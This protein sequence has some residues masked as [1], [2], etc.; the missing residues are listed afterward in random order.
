MGTSA[1]SPIR[2]RAAP[3]AETDYD[4]D[5]DGL[6]EVRQPRPAQRDSLRPR[7]RRRRGRLGQP[8]PITTP[9]SRTRRATSAMTTGTGATTETCV[10]YELAAD[11]DFDERRRR[12]NHVRRRHLLERQGSGLGAD[13]DR[14]RFVQGC[15]RGQRSYDQPTSSSA[16]RASTDDVGLFGRRAAPA[17]LSAACGAW[18][19]STSPGTSLRGGIGESAPVGQ[20]R[21]QLAPPCQKCGATGSHCL[22]RLL[23]RS[24]SPDSVAAGG[25]FESWASVDVSG[26]SSRIGGF[27]GRTPSAGPASSP[28]TPP[29]RVTGVGGSQT[30]IGGLVGDGQ[31][32]TSGSKEIHCELCL[33]GP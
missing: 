6:I 12:L 16:G 33:P 11:L 2:S 7:R 23:L 1:A 13:R 20:G 30:I 21:L 25:V 14:F 32:S 27:A 29:A 31:G 24:V 22:R 4:T 5:D 9:R 8:R 26:P 10:G 17:R 15:L 28:A 19:V 3:G 18:R